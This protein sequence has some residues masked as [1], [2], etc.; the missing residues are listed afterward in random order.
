MLDRPPDVDT[1][2]YAFVDSDAGGGA[3]ATVYADRGRV[4]AQS[5]GVTSPSCW[6]G[7]WRTKSGIFCSEPIGMPATG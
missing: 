5:A 2:G 6:A 1:L 7:R 4:M 3:L